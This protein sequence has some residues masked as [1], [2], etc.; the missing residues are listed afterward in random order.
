[1]VGGVPMYLLWQ[2]FT[3][4]SK[5]Y[6]SNKYTSYIGAYWNKTYVVFWTLEISLYC[7]FIYFWF[8]S[9][10]APQA[11]IG[12]AITIRN[13]T[14]SMKVCIKAFFMLAWIMVIS[15]FT[16]IARNYHN[17]LL[18]SIGYALLMPPHVILLREEY[19]YFVYNC[20]EWGAAVKVFYTTE[21][22]AGNSDV[23]VGLRTR[24]VELVPDTLDLIKSTVF[25]RNK[26]ILCSYAMYSI[27]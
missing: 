18:M 21:L 23:L 17:K 3:Y 16:L 4:F 22:L 19:A 5:L 13:V 6:T 9:P 7:L 12:Q 15:I 27:I 24:P 14:V 25:N 8:I 11:V 2:T 20:A 10:E 1:M 26:E